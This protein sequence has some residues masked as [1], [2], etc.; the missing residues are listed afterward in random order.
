[1]F[2]K[3]NNLKLVKHKKLIALSQLKSLSKKYVIFSK[4]RTLA[5]KNKAIFIKYQSLIYFILNVM[6]KK[7]NFKKI[8][9]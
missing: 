7:K 3:N 8:W 6:V 9:Y 5:F 1:L 4:M 2:F